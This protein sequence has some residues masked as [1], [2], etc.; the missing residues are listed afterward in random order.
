MNTRATTLAAVCPTCTIFPGCSGDDPAAGVGDACLPE[1]I[2]EEG[3]DRNRVYV[4]T[5]SEDCQTNV[6][7]VYRLRGDP[8]PATCVDP[9]VE[10]A[11]PET[12]RVCQQQRCA[13]DET[14]KHRVHCSCRCDGSDAC[15]CP[16][17]FSC[18]EV[19][20]GTPQESYCVR[21]FIISD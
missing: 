3:F 1:L 20:F 15:S 9:D 12:A 21:D 4:E 19:G 2:P 16:E 18:R 5:G 17:G 8:N 6:C 14:H 13:L 11:D 10:C 7:L